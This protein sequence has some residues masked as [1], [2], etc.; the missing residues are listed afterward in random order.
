MAGRRLDNAGAATL[1]AGGLSLSN[2]AVLTNLAGATFDVHTPTPAGIGEVVLLRPGAV[3]HGWSQSQ[4]L[5]E[6]VI[7][8]TTA[9]AVQVQAPPDGTIAPPG[10]YLLFVLTPGRVPSV[11]RW[12]RLA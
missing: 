2:G 8:G 10:P 9:A 1:T 12:I 7:T 4:R 5:I 6:C 3:T 11:G